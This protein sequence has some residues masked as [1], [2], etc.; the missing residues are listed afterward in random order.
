MFE[1]FFNRLHIELIETC[2]VLILNNF[3]SFQSKTLTVPSFVELLPVFLPKEILN[4]RE[5]NL[6]PHSL[7]DIE[8]EAAFNR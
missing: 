4:S 6:W 8:C 5:F 7:R 2:I 1:F 3:G